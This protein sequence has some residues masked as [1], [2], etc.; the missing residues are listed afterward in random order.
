M[1]SPDCTVSNA[2]STCMPVNQAAN[3]TVMNN[4]ILDALTGTP[5]AR[6]LGD[7]PPTAKIQLPT[8]VRNNTHVP[9]AMNASHQNTVTFTDTPNTGMSE[10]KIAL[11]ESNPS[12]VE[13]S[14]VDTF[15]V[16]IFV[17]PRLSPCSIRNV[18]SVTRKL[19]NPVRTSS[20]PLN[21]PI[22]RLT[23]SATRMPTHR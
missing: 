11:A 14:F 23:A 2:N 20:H 16:K 6:A 3:T 7:L 13:M 15:P 8:L 9:S 17:M 19:G 10:A 21:A 12:M 4:P 5:P 22:P 1:P 18:A